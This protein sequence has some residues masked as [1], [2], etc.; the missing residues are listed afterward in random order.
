M[1]QETK[2]RFGWH[3]WHKWKKARMM[4]ISH[5]PSGYVLESLPAPKREVQE[6]ERECLCCGLIEQRLLE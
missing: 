1:K 5:H 6:I 4:E 3:D 2:C